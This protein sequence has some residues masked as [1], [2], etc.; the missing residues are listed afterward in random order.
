MEYLWETH[1]HT[2]ET[3]KCA[4]ATGAEMA[5][6]YAQAGYQG[7]VVT[8]H[9][10]NGNA[11]RH[12]GEPWAARIG[13]F[14]EGYRAA[15]AAGEALGLCVLFGW[16]YYFEGGD[17]L[18]F[19]LSEAFL[20]DNPDLCEIDLV[21]YGARVHRAGGFIS[22]AHPFRE[23]WY[24]PPDAK[25]RVDVVD[26]LEVYNASPHH[27]EWNA[28]AEALA[29]QHHLLRTAGSDAHN[30]TNAAMAAMAFDAPIV[31]DKAFLAALRSGKGRIVK[32]G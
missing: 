19:G 27:D 20:L 23:A 25:Q 3:S 6:A 13:H 26:A 24:I 29:A 15:K 9:F 28:K 16:E 31:G 4:A 21:E 2:A 11:Y 8:D 5:A 12:E 22:Q 30:T 32:R 1:M 17:Y 14:M 7:I 18:T 10:L